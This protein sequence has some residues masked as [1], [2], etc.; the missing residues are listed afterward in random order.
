MQGVLLLPSL[1]KQLE[2]I[3]GPINRAVGEITKT[4]EYLVICL[5][6]RS[7]AF[8]KLRNEHINLECNETF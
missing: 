5:G 8:V 1:N 4:S 2:L 6:N 3:Q 7:Y